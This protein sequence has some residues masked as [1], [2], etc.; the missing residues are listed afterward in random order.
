MR[1][2][3][4]G[5]TQSLLKL[6]VVRTKDREKTHKNRNL[7]NLSECTNPLGRLPAKDAGAWGFSWTGFP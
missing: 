4:R 6:K 3:L 7:A 2:L 1:P 5:S